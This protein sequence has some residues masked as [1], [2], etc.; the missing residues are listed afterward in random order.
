MK[1]RSRNVRF[2]VSN[3]FVSQSFTYHFVRGAKWCISLRKHVQR[4]RVCFTSNLSSGDQCR[5]SLLHLSYAAAMPAIKTRELICKNRFCSADWNQSVAG[6]SNFSNMSMSV[7]IT[8]SF[9]IRRFL[10]FLCQSFPPFSRVLEPRHTK[11]RCKTMCWF[12][13]AARPWETRLS[14]RQRATPATTAKNFQ[15][16]AYGNIWKPS[17]S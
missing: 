3:A 16:M 7:H 10:A 12:Q 6:F 15:E 2:K 4:C 1:S 17:W 13:L 8:S 11:C 14:E 5:L 9:T